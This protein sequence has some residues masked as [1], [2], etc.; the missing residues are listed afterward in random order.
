MAQCKEQLS[1]QEP[2]WTKVR[3]LSLKGSELPSLEA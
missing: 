2:G 3:S 1:G